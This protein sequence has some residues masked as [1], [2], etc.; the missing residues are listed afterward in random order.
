MISGLSGSAVMDYL[1]PLSQR[2]ERAASGLKAETA[3]RDGEKKTGAEA[4]KADATAGGATGSANE[5]SKEDQRRVEELARTDR[6][7]RQHEQAHMAAGGGLITSR[8]SY[9]YETGPDGKRYAVAGEVG[10]SLAEGRTPEETLQR[11]RRIRA[12]ALAPAD[13]SPQDRSVAAMAGQMEMEAMQEI[14][15]RQLAEQNGSGE[16]PDIGAQNGAEKQVPPERVRAE[17]IRAYQTMADGAGGTNEAAA[18]D[19]NRVSLFA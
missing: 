1:L 2:G 6:A 16:N 8:A 7:V 4:E 14:A 10:I 11:A 3:N 18:N 9:E 5:L 15:R 19:A 12:A 17:G 13:P